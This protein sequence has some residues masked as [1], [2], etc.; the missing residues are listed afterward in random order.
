MDVDKLGGNRGIAIDKLCE[1]NFHVWK[2]K[3]NF[4]LTYREVDHVISLPNTHREGTTEH[5][6]PRNCRTVTIR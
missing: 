4:I 2:Q 5:I 3:I 1:S 6:S